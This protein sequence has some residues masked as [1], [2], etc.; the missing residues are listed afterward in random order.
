MCIIS[1]V[2]LGELNSVYGINF[3]EKPE[4]RPITW[5]LIPKILKNKPADDNLDIY[6]YM[7]V[8]DETKTVSRMPSIDKENVKSKAPAQ[9][10]SDLKKIAE[11]IE[12][13][14]ISNSKTFNV[15]N[16][17]SNSNNSDNKHDIV[18]NQDEDKFDG[19]FYSGNDED[20]D[21]K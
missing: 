6:K 20:D 11:E 14:D 10:R 2:L 5:A 21:C 3:D 17:I 16:Q 1:F 13:D 18:S 8:A 19:R 9:K 12:L 4:T 15:I 7:N